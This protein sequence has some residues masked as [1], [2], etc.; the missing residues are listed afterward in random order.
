[1]LSPALTNRA[2]LQSALARI[3]AACGTLNRYK[4]KADAEVDLGK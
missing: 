4:S 1:M 3:E 2:A